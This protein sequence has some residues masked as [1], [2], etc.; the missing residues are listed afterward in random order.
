MDGVWSME[1]EAMIKNMMYFTFI[2]S[3]NT[4]ASELSKFV[5][6]TGVREIIAVSHIYNHE[7]RLK[8]Y[9]ILSDIFSE[10]TA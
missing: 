5:E 4:I 7:A 9:K 1:Q 10:T 2:G 8:S 3:K 6:S